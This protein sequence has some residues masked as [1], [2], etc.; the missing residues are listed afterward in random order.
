MKDNLTEL[1][2]K[3]VGNEAEDILR[4]FLN[5]YGDKVALASS[6]SIED[7]VLLDMLLK[8]NG[9]AKI[10]TI[11]TGRLPYETY[12]LID[13]TKSFYNYNL[14]IYFPASTNVE[15]MVNE[16]GVNL[17]YESVENRKLC[18]FNRK[19][20]PLKRALN[21]LDA[22]ICGLRTE[23]SITR[24]NLEIV[25]Y[26]ES[27]LLLKINPLLHWTENQVWEY[28]KENNVPYNKL[29]DNGYLSI[30]CAPCSRA[31]EPGED[32]RSGRWWW[33]NPDTKECGLHL[34]KVEQNELPR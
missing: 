19:V 24:Q 34:K 26:D 21:G 13:R 12:S 2:L 30:G 7:Q 4:Y 25:E 23:Q 9:N 22:W 27:N 32:I 10:F 15:N 14:E 11:D 3:F 28:I 1:N 8:I 20:E 5:L 17:F 31:V 6:L 18:C 16:R 29:Y 33:E